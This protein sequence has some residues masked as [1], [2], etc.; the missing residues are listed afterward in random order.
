MKELSI[1]KLCKRCNNSKKLDDFYRRRKG[2]DTSPYCKPCMK[3][4]AL[5]RQRKLKLDAI[6]YK[7][8]KCQICDYAKCTSALEFHHRRPIDKSFSVSRAN[9]TTFAKIQTELDKCDLLCANCHRET[10]CAGRCSFCDA[11]S[12]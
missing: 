2:S 8:G 3:E 1:I 10:E 6:K 7:G 12:C 5:S 9:K 11:L 4:Q